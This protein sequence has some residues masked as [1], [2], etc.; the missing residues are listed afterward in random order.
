MSTLETTTYAK[1]Q[2]EYLPLPTIRLRNGTVVT[3]W[4]LTWAE[5][6]R[7]L[8]GGSLWLTVM[9]FHKPLQPVMLT[10]ECPIKDHSG[11]V[12]VSTP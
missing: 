5:R 9:T 4:K 10:T 3:R 2:P 7:V 11:V 6:L 12:E 1:N 8:L